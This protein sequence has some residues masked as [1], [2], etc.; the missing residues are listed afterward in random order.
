MVK[1]LT[2]LLEPTESSRGVITRPEVPP[3]PSWAL[4]K[5]SSAAGTAPAQAYVASAGKPAIVG[6]VVAFTVIVCVLLDEFPQASLAT[7][8]RETVNRLT[9]ILAEI[10]ST[11]W[12][13]VTEP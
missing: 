8:V 6:A 5:E 1:R 7:Y 12:L 13:I 2:Q 4:T 3:H 11:E 9:Q 10:T